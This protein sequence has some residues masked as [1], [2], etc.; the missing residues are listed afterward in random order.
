MINCYRILLPVNLTSNIQESGLYS[1]KGVVPRSKM[2][3][4]EAMDICIQLNAA[5]RVD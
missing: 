3:N 1:L 5:G 2:S 4:N